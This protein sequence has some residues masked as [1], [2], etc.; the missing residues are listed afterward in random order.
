VPVIGIN[1]DTPHEIFR[2]EEQRRS[3]NRIS[4]RGAELFDGPDTAVVIHD[5]ARSHA[6]SRP[7]LFGTTFSSVVLPLWFHRSLIPTETRGVSA[8]RVPECATSQAFTAFGL[9]P[10]E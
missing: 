8:L 5:D 3:L 6:E 2:A 7:K 10:T 4:R 1:P 9:A